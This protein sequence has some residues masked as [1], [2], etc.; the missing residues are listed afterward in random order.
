MDPKL[1]NKHR[2]DHIKV[3]RRTKNQIVDTTFPCPQW[4]AQESLCQLNQ[5]MRQYTVG[6][7][8]YFQC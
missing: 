4:K 3:V 8:H 6:Q 2:H 1:S 5:Q 7:S